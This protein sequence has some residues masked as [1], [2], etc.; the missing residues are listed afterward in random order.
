MMKSP[1]YVESEVEVE[2]ESSMDEKK[3]KREFLEHD[4]EQ[5]KNFRNKMLNTMHVNAINKNLVTP[6]PLD[7]IRSGKEQ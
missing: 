1:T 4:V 2:K 5:I 6:M 3:Q 7:T